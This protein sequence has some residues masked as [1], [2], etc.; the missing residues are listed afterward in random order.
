[1]KV[2]P[3]RKFVDK[4]SQ[5]NF[6]ENSL[7]VQKLQSFGIKGRQEQVKEFKSSGSN[8]SLAVQTQKAKKV[9]QTQLQNNIADMHISQVG[10][11]VDI[12][13]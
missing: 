13:A 4:K 5:G 2:D 8:I 12:K 1:M 10:K 9:I 3:V 11:R 7:V 6:G